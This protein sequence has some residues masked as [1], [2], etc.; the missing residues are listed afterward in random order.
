[1][2]EYSD[3]HHEVSHEE[4]TFLEEVKDEWK[5]RYEELKLVSDAKIAELEEKCTQL[6]AQVATSLHMTEQSE[7]DSLNQ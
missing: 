7:V 2:T 6:E 5:D 4:A 1:M 3:A